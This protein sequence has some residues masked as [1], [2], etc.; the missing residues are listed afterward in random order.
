MDPVKSIPDDIWHIKQS[1]FECVRRIGDHFST[2]NS[3]F[4][5][6][7]SVFWKSSMLTLI[8]VFLLLYIFIKGKNKEEGR[9]WSSHSLTP[10]VGSNCLCITETALKS[11]QASSD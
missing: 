11:L 5:L 6:I 4:T 10:G 3:D 9:A 2:R 8:L 7:K 1:C